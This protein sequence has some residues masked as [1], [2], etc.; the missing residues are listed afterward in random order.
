MAIWVQVVPSYSQVS[1]NPSVALNP[2][3]PTIF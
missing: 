1:L 2:A 3:V